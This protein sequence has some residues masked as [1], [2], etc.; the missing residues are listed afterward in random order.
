MT[1]AQDTAYVDVEGALLADADADV[2]SGPGG[3]SV[4]GVVFA[5][6]SPDGDLV[7][8]LPEARFRELAERGVAVPFDDVPL[9]AKGVWA[10]VQDTEDW[11]ELATEA[12]QFVGEPAVGRDS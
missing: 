10:L 3:L 2:R 7:V 5:L 8:D 4:D 9:Q 6:R 12:H 11:V 1:E